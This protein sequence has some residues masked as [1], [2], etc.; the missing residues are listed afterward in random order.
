MSKALWRDALRTH[1]ER[2]PFDFVD[3][4]SPAILRALF[5]Q[6]AIG[7][8][9]VDSEGHLLLV[10]G[11]FGAIT[12]HDPEA[13]NGRSFLSI[14][15]PEDVKRVTRL[16]EKADSDGKE[17]ITYDPRNVRQ[18]ESVVWVRAT[19]S[20]LRDEAGTVV[21]FASFIQDVTTERLAV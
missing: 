3:S 8:A 11:A 10:N 7:I 16:I 15:H 5:D 6:S 13:L 1:R 12:G 18:N 19:V 4:L 14:T 17:S 9:M 20:R 2:T 21:A